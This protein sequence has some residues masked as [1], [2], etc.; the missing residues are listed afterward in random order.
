MTNQLGAQQKVGI[1]RLLLGTSTT[2]GLSIAAVMFAA[3][4]S[5]TNAQPSPTPIRAQMEKITSGGQQRTYYVL[6][7]PNKKGRLPLVVALHGST[8]SPQGLEF[9]AN[10][11]GEA[12]AAGFVVVYPEGIGFEWNTGNDPQAT[13]VDDVGFVRAVIDHMVATGQADPKHVFATGISSGAEM[14]HRLACELSDRIAAVASVSGDLGVA[15]CSP[16]QPI[17]ILEI[18]GTADPF[19]PIAGDPSNN[20]PPT[21][22]TMHRW[23]QIDG[24]APVPAVNQSGIATMTAW[25]GCHGGV[26]V[27]L[28]TIAGAGHTFWLDP[29]SGQPDINQMIWNFLSRAPDR[30]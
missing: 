30:G 8:Q 25:S 9:E 20:F 12:I 23:V 10:L 11:D 6:H 14:S 18:H 28:V 26:T 1:R 16:T 7:P 29:I 2:L 15:V 17:S 22:T 3:C 19:V 21:M 24:C 5:T 4:G 27:V 13:N